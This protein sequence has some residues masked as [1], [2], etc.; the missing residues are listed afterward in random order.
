VYEGDKLEPGRKSLGVEVVLQP[1]EKTL[2]ETAIEAVSAKIVA[3][4]EKIGAV[5]R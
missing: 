2:T 4:A 1:R 3:A 5:L